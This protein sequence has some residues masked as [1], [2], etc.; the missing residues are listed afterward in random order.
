MDEIWAR[1]EMWLGANAHKVLVSLRPGASEDTIAE[2]EK[3]LG[4]ILPEDVK[5]SYRIHD[6]QASEL[7]IMMPKGEF[8]SLGRIM[9]DWSIL[10]DVYDRGIFNK[11]RSKPAA[12]VKNDWWNPAW[13]PFTYD[14]SGNHNCI[15][16]DP[17]KEGTI[18]QVIQMWHDDSERPLVASSF[19]AWLE[20]LADELEAGEYM[21]SDE[22]L[23]M[24][25][26]EDVLIYLEQENGEG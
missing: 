26:T 25:R 6:G 16:L 4:V 19:T 8:L 11:S 23:G 5:A 20:Q 3:A 12:G 15:D 10:K 2:T 7:S 21:L 9:I 13:I 24:A 1:I 18:G 22:F 17:D 14:G